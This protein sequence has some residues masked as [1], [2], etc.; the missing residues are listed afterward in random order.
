MTLRNPDRRISYNR[1]YQQGMDIKEAQDVFESFF[2]TNGIE[3]EMEKEFFKEHFPHIKVS[4]YEVL[5]IPATSTFEETQKAYRTLVLK[6]HPIAAKHDPEAEKKFIQITEAYRELVER[7]KVS[8]LQEQKREKDKDMNKAAQ[9]LL[10][11]IVK[12][13]SKV[14]GKTDGEEKPSKKDTKLAKRDSEK[15]QDK[16][17]R[18]RIE[19]NRKRDTL[20]SSSESSDR[21]RNRSKSTSSVSSRDQR[22]YSSKRGAE[23]SHDG[24]D[25]QQL[26]SVSEERRKADN[27][28]RTRRTK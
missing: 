21:D 8:K 17:S 9:V 16:K 3:G 18:Q 23:I 28:T 24:E 4:P 5:E 26:S 10:K 15:R 2:H 20:R 1:T 13:L 12:K 22:K 19:K 6:T 11:G 14:I 7:E 27:H 25:I